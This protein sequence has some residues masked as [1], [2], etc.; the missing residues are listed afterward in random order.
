MLRLAIYVGG[1]AVA[2]A[3]L[4]VWRDQQR[5]MRRVPVKQAA[6]LLR[7]AWADNHTRA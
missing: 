1:V 4:V 5:A 6:D 7:K 2:L 3:A